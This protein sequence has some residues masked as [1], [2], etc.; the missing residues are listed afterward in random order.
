MRGL[1]RTG[2]IRH[3]RLQED[4]RDR[5]EAARHP[6]GIHTNE[7]PHVRPY[8]RRC[9]LR[10]LGA[11]FC[12]CQQSCQLHRPLTRDRRGFYLPAEHYCAVCAQPVGTAVPSTGGAMRRLLAGLAAGALLVT[13]TACGSSDAPVRASDT[14]TSSGGT[15]TVKVGRDPDR[16]CRPDLSGQKKG[17][18]SEARA[19]TAIDDRPGRRGDRARCGQRPVPVRLQQHDLADG[20]PVQERAGQGRRE[21]RRLHRR[22]RAR[23][24]GLR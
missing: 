18:F 21:R 23:T 20:R 7:A 1:R 12:N 16:R 10:T 5:A 13:A 9:V 6:H 4:A 2:S 19:R 8:A 17:F 3:R 15:T 14:G 24:S 11:H 22:G